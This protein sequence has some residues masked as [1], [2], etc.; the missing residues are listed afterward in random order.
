MRSTP[1]V[2]AVSIAAA[3][4]ACKVAEP[5]AETATD[6]SIPAPTTMP[7]LPAAT[8]PAAVEP[9][10]DTYRY[11]CGDLAVTAVF[12]GPEGGVDLDI[13]GRK[14]AL[15]HATSGSGARY[16][17]EAGNEFWSKGT[18]QAMLTL[19]GE[20]RRDCSGS[21]T[22][23]ADGAA[24]TNADADAVAAD[25][26]TTLPVRFESGKSLATLKG[27]FKGYDT[28]EYKLDARAGQTITVKISGSSNAN[29]NLRAPGSDESLSLGSDGQNYS[30]TLPVSGEY[31]V[32]VF[33]MRASARRGTVV[34]YSL[35][36]E[37]R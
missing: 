6:P 7:E 28:V 12:H 23:V 15:P 25:Q 24:N 17:D 3:L 13:D 33:Q 18:T 22:S 5:S 14:L 8:T 27:S 19:A 26:V 11:Q 29:F 31:T 16:A 20:K 35:A 30:G 36:I 21:A 34:P 32:Q 4:V 10:G 1:F 9:V 37:V 2:L